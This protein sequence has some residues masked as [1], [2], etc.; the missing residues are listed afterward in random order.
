MKT[1]ITKDYYGKTLMM[2]NL[3]IDLVLSIVMD[4]TFIPTVE[5]H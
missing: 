5:V 4:V 3:S 2:E 1:I